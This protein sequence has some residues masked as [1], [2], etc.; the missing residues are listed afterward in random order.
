MV[1]IHTAEGNRFVSELSGYNR[2]WIGGRI[3][4]EAKGDFILTWSDG[5]PDNFQTWGP[6]DPSGDGVKL[7]DKTII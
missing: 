3:E 7:N 2:I 4:W 6:N 1:S 5:T